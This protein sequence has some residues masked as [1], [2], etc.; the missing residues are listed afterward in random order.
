MTD[1]DAMLAIQD[2]LDGQ[3]WSPDTLEDIAKIMVNAGYRI[4]DAE[5][6]DREYCPNEMCGVLLYP[7]RKTCANCGYHL[8]D[9]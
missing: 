4:R 2:L 6:I 5:D 3:V 7:G 1:Y 8:Y 9:E